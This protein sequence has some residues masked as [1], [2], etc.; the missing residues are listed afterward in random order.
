MSQQAATRAVPS[1]SMLLTKLVVVMKW[2][3]RDA[4]STLRL[5]QSPVTLL[6]VF[7][8]NGVKLVGNTALTDAA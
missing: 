7:V 6:I 8:T 3:V 1:G 4:L 5:D 2:S